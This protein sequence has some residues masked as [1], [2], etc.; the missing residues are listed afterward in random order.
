MELQV[1]IAGS[2][3]ILL[4]VIH[5][6]FPK[7]F[8]WKEDLNFLS[9]VNR[10]MMQVHTFFVA[11]VLLLTGVLCISS[12]AEL[13]NTPLGK[14]ISLGIGIFWACRLLIQFFGYSSELWKGKSFE[15]M[16]HIVFSLLWIYFTFL[17]LKIPLYNNFW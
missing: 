11:L 2:I 9:P 16:V 13:I 1:K 5:A 14:S 12:S 6:S 10:Q 8:R 17:F 3:M 7:Y 15:T 4:A